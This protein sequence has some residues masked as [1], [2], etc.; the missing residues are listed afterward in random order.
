MWRSQRDLARQVCQ[1]ASPAAEG[2]Q[3]SSLVVYLE[4]ISGRFLLCLYDIN[5]AEST[6]FPGDF[7]ISSEEQVRQQCL[8]LPYCRVVPRH[9]SHHHHI[10]SLLLSR[11]PFLCEIRGWSAPFVECLSCFCFRDVLL[12]F[13]TVAFRSSN[14]SVR[15]MEL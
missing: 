15:V 6:G 12:H 5:S 11:C 2:E 14:N 4:L 7:Q 13:P 3:L 8:P 1:V 9:A 10:S